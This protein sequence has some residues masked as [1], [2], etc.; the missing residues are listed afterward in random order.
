MAVKNRHI[1]FGYR[2]ERG[3]YALHDSEAATVRAVFASYLA[4]D[5]YT[6]I[7]RALNFGIVPY[8]DG[9]TWN[10]HMVKRML[11]NRRYVGDERYPMIITAEIFGAANALRASKPS[12]TQTHKPKPERNYDCEILPYRPNATVLKLS[13]TINR[14][15]ERAPDPQQLRPLIFELAAEKYAAI[16]VRFADG[17]DDAKEISNG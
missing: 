2:I 8:S 14:A 13:N 16:E 15:L 9:A 10:K 4:G 3:E 5:G 6:T 11:E 17:N 7:T 1:P 12:A